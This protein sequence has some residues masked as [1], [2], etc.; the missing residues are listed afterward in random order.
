MK[1]LSD[2]LIDWT[3]QLV[4]PVFAAIS[5]QKVALFPNDE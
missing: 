1:F 2:T 3:A 4:Y 5:K